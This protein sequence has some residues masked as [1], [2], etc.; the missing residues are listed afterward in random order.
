VQAG[1]NTHV[2]LKKKNTSCGDTAFIF[3][4]LADL[5]AHVN[6]QWGEKK[7][8][9]INI[10]NKKYFKNLSKSKTDLKL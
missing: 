10:K 9:Y 7:R 4:F 2:K 8:V 1:P 5:R 6:V 3:P